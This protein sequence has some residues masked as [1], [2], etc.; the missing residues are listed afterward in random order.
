MNGELVTTSKGGAIGLFRP[1]AA[2]LERLGAWFDSE[3][4]SLLRFA[5]F[6][7]G[8]AASAEDLVQDAFVRLY[9]S[10]GRLE[11]PAF[12]AYARRTIANLG[13]SGFRRTLRERRALQAIADPPAPREPEARDDVWRAILSLPP[14][15]RACVALRFYEDLSETDIAGTLGISPGSVKTHLNRAMTKLRASLGDRREP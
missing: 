13:R 8:E 6:V 4:P 2:R 9:H 15:Q 3:Y 14:Q 11:D 1:S 12:P 7:T 10:A 5:Y